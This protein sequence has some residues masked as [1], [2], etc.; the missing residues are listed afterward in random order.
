MPIMEMEK[1]WRIWNQS[2]DED[3]GDERFWRSL[4]MTSDTLVV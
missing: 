4:K 1:N 3:D 2:G